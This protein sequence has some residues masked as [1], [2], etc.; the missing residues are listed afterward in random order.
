LETWI[1]FHEMLVQDSFPTD[2]ISFLLILDVIC[3]LS[4]ESTTRMTYTSEVKEFWRTGY[5]LFHGKFL[6]FINYVRPQKLRS[7]CPGV[8]TEGLPEPLESKDKLCSSKC[9]LSR[10]RVNLE[11]RNWTWGLDR[12]CWCHF[13]EIKLSC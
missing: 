10:K 7:D 4:C 8:G 6:R 2:N 12:L 13:S 1:I 11:T 3:F 9:Q 5:R